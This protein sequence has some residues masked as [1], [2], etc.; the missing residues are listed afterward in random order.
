MSD[1]RLLLID[2]NSITYKAFF[3][4]IKLVDRFTNNEGVH[5]NAIYGFNNMLNI[6]LDKVKPTH[7]LVA[8]DAG[9]STFRT[10]MYSDYK[11]G[12]DK[13]PEEL[14]EQFDY[15]KELLKNRGIKYYQLKNYEADDI[16]GTLS[17]QAD[18]LGFDTTIVTGDNDLTQLCSDK[19][20]VSISNRGVSGVVRYDTDYVKETMGI[21]PEQIIDWKA[22]KGDSSD[23]Y[24]GVTGVG[25]KTSLKLVKQFGSVENLYDHLDEVSGKKLKE[26]LIED[27]DEAFLAKKLARINRE[28]PIEISIDDTEYEGDHIDDLIAFYRQMNFRKFLSEMNTTQNANMKDIEYVE[29]SDDTLS[30]I[31]EQDSDKVTFYLGMDGDNYH[32]APFIGFALKINDKIYVSNDVEYLK[33]NQIKQIIESNDV[34]K[35]V[36]DAKRTYVGLNRLGITLNNVDFDLLLSSYL[37]DTNDNSN[38]LGKVANRHDYFDVQSDDDVYGKGAKR[39]IP[40]GDK[41]FN[42]FARK[43]NAIDALKDK[44]FDGLKENNQWDLY[45]DVELPLTFVLARMEIAGVVVDKDVLNEMQSKLSERLEEIKQNIYNDAGEEFNIASPKQ[46][47]VILFEKLQLPVIKKTK[48]GYSTAVGVLEQLA[49]DYPI[50]EA[51][52]EY[53]QLSKILSTYVEGLLSDIHGDGKVH[54]RYLQTLTQTGRLSSVDP[55]LQNIPVRTEEGRK[56]RQAFVPSHDNYQIF[57]SDYSQIELR[58]LASISGDKNMQDEFIHNDDIHASTARRIFGLKDNSEVTPELRRQAKAVNFGIVYGISDFGLAKNTGISRKDAKEF[59]EKYFAEYPGVKNYMD[60]SVENAKKNGYVETILH[61]RR[62]L[63]DINS[64]N[65]NLRSFAER[66]AM[67]SPI[68]GSAA[69]IIKIAMIK[70]ENEL[71]KRGMKA[72]MLLQVHDELIFEAPDEEIEVLSELVPK[73][74]DSA[75]ELNVPLNVKSHYGKNWYSLK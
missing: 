67:N 41:L 19:T 10:E 68:Q 43:L 65:F 63:P 27:K 6:M 30:E 5:T 16:I 66:T 14:V 50:V 54:T 2:G 8:F 48:T 72:K 31:A 74:M 11:A 1:K 34:K 32:D 23:N 13:T 60:E 21:T 25:D 7:V 69:D 4:L 61:R 36:F 53:R 45:T 18:G 33:S 73:V 62:Y 29:V 70:M 44:L 3:A 42:H 28:A 15:V 12:R 58:V 49:P 64:K 20:T 57:S 38:D 51:I 75:V 46:L 17:K 24:S 22:L 55:N 9:K 35:D 40:E 26:H 59:I 71:N 47:G 56:I 52:L 39:E 37:L